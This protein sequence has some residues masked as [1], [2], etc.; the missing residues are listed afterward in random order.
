MKTGVVMALPGQSSERQLHEEHTMVASKHT[1][2]QAE[3]AA[4]VIE[5]RDLRRFL[6]PSRSLF[7]MVSYSRLGGTAPALLRWC[8]LR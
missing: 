3:R 8:P 4:S 6:A 5:Q 2:R 7:T 1:V